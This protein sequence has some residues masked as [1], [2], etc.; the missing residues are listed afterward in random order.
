MTDVRD[1]A[2]LHII[3]PA[4][5]GLIGNNEKRI[6]LILSAYEGATR[7]VVENAVARWDTYFTGGTQPRRYLGE[8]YP[9]FNPELKDNIQWIDEER[10]FR[11][12]SANIQWTDEVTIPPALHAY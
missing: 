9:K 12:S 4:F 2:T 8:E 11:V 5:P 1:N 3:D 10:I 6:A 7:A